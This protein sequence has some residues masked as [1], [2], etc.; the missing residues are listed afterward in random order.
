MGSTRLPGKSM[1]DLAG[2]SLVFRLLERVKR[3]KNLDD[4][5][6]AIPD[7]NENN[8]L[9][10][11]A[12]KLNIK[13]YKGSETDVLDRYYCAAKKFNADIVGRIPADN[14]LSEPLEIDRI[15]A[16]HRELCV[17]GFSS[18]LAAVYNSSYPDGIGAEMFDFCL[19]ENAWENETDHNKREHVH[20]NFYNYE[21]VKAVD[22]EKCPVST[23][24][25]PVEYQRPDLILDVNTEEQYLYIKKIYEYFYENNPFF[26]I[27]DIIHWHD[28]IYSKKL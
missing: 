17:P 5:V 11:E 24:P 26:N 23:I 3:C 19:L 28:N 25:C 20:L 8:I 12:K 14:P 22:N 16:H 15:A 10:F 9:A 27:K 21:T 13:V 1:M 6:L 2:A 7:N 18:N 4:I